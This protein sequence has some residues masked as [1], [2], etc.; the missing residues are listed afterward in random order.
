MIVS[1]EF[2]S[3]SELNAVKDQVWEGARDHLVWPATVQKPEL[4]PSR[5]V[6]AQVPRPFGHQA[7][8]G[9]QAGYR[10]AAPSSTLTLLCTLGAGAVNPLLGGAWTLGPSGLPA[11]PGPEETRLLH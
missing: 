4:R 5:K 11:L 8:A 3:K 2:D 1:T 6:A 10:A 7:G 9:T